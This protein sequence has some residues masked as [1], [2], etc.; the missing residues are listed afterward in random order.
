MIK[1]DETEFPHIISFFHSW[2]S[3]FSNLA[4]L[5]NQGN[6]TWDMYRLTLRFHSY[7]YHSLVQ[8]EH[9]NDKIPSLHIQFSFIQ[10]RI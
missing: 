8:L 9:K 6:H 10:C 5:S 2:L 3:S 4:L 1:W 7:T